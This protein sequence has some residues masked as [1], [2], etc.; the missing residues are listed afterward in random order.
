MSTIVENGKMTKEVSRLRELLRIEIHFT[1][2][3]V[4]TG[5]LVFPTPAPDGG[6]HFVFQD[7]FSRE[8]FFNCLYED[9]RISLSPVHKCSFYKNNVK[10]SYGFLSP[11]RKFLPL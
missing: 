10:I 9:L 4:Q 6:F 5:L 7:G 2:N 8:D 11:P 3:H 1:F